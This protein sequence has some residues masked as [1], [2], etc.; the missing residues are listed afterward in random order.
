[1]AA[2]ALSREEVIPGEWELSVKTFR[3]LEAQHGLALQADLFASPLNHKLPVYFCP[4]SFP[5]AQGKDA[6]VQDWNLFEQVLIFP[7]PNLIEEV[8]KKLIAYKGGGVLVLLDSRALLRFIPTRFLRK[9]LE[10]DSPFQ[11][12]FQGSVRASE[13]YARFR[14]WSF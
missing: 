3:S 12:L 11:H 14:A 13:G 5:Q 4:F 1:M 7:P 2:D 6:L 9:E 8:A 10:M